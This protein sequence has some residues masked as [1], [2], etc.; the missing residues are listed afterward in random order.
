MSGFAVLGLGPVDFS[1]RLC[2]ASS[3]TLMAIFLRVCHRGPKARKKEEKR[4]K[5]VRHRTIVIAI[6]DLGNA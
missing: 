4:P 3:K 6:V 1:T 5:K 2:G